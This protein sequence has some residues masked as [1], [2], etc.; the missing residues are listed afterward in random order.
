MQPQCDAC[1]NA[2]GNH[3]HDVCTEISPRGD[4][5]ACLCRPCTCGHPDGEH[6]THEPHRCTE[7]DCPALRLVA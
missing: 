1:L 4:A 2:P 5:C 7:C 6:S 3:T